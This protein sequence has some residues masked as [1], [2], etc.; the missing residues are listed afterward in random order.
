MSDEHPML[1]LRLETF[2]ATELRRGLERRSLDGA[3]VTAPLRKKPKQNNKKKVFFFEKKKKKLAL[4]SL[5]SCSPP[6]EMQQQAR[7]ANKIG[8]RSRTA[9]KNLKKKKW[10]PTSL[11]DVEQRKKKSER[12]KE[13][14]TCA[15][16]GQ[17]GESGGAEFQTGGN[18]FFFVVAHARN[19]SQ[20]N[21][22]HL[23]FFLFAA[24]LFL[25]RTTKPTT[26]ARKI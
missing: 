15:D 9:G 11:S 20:R 4:F 26:Q 3:S 13:I 10:R 23:F 1:L 22:L 17:D 25:C 16:E 14:F 5:K 7:S 18:S 19:H 12:G 8:C 24:F 6:L 2:A 21:T